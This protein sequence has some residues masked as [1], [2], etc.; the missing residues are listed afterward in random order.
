M[1][2]LAPSADV[3]SNYVRLHKIDVICFTETWLKRGE[4]NVPVGNLVVAGR[5]VRRKKKGGGVAIYCRSDLTFSKLTSPPLSASSRLELLWI[6]VKCG[7]N[8]SL[9]IGYV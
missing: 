2:S 1:R 3:V 9:I 5:L 7:H 4:P 6:S 8:R